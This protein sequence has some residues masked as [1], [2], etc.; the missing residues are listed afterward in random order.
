MLALRAG[1]DGSDIFWVRPVAKRYYY[2]LARASEDSPWRIEFSAG[3]L[4]D[5]QAKRDNYR[6]H[7]K[8]GDL[9]IVSVADDH[10]ATIKAVISELNEKL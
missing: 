1:R 5:V 8:V 9:K 10:L 6:A 7:D 2:L 4:Q 3:D